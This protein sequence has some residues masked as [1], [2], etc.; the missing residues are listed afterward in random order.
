MLPIYA[1][2]SAHGTFCRRKHALHAWPSLPW[3]ETA[4]DCGNTWGTKPRCADRKHKS[5]GR[6]PCSLECTTAQREKAS[7]SRREKRKSA[8]QEGQHRRL[9]KHSSVNGTGSLLRS[10]SVDRAGHTLLVSSSRPSPRT[11]GR[12]FPRARSDHSGRMDTCLDTG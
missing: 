10:R 7:A 12:H 5:Y 6:K 8:G 11:R 9:P 4:R 2:W 3:L 1:H